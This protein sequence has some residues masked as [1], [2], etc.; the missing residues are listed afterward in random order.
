MFEAMLPV[1]GLDI[2]QR[3]KDHRITPS[4]RGVFGS[5]LFDGET[6][7]ERGV[8]RSFPFE[9][10]P[11]HGEIEGLAE[12][13]GTG[14]QERLGGIVQHRL[15]ERGFVDVVVLLP[16][17]CRKVG[18]TD[19][20]PGFFRCGGGI[21]PLFIVS[22]GFLRAFVFEKYGSIVRVTFYNR[23]LEV[24]VLFGGV[25]ANVSNSDIHRHQAAMHTAYTGT[26]PKDASIDILCIDR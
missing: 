10:G 22:V 25:S 17:Q 1:S 2:L 13:P 24:G 20:R 18:E 26:G 6:L 19:G 4:V 12:A 23:Q 15:D 14:K 5:R 7:K 11:E 16:D 9:E 3:Q 8:F 21:H